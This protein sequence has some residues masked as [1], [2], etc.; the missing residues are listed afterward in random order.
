MCLFTLYGC[1]CL[2]VF[3]AAHLPARKSISL[4]VHL[5]VCVFVLLYL[6]VYVCLPCL[7]SCFIYPCTSHLSVV[8]FAFLR[9][10]CSYLVSLPGCVV[11]KAC[12]HVYGVLYSN[13]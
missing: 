3:V 6:C 9:L 1:I 4:H 12:E 2:C 5:S 10:S 8:V 7:Y 11:A 13:M